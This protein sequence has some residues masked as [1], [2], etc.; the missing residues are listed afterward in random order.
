M[1]P[2]HERVTKLLTDTVTLLCKNGLSYDRELR[3]QGLLGITVDSKEVFLVSINDSFSCSSESSLASVTSPVAN[4]TASASSLPRNRSGDEVVDLTRLVETPNVFTAVQPPQLSS[5]IS[6]MQRGSQTRPRSAGSISQTKS[7][8]ATLNSLNMTLPHHHSH[9]VARQPPISTAV[10]SV[11]HRTSTS[12]RSSAERLAL[13]YNNQ[14]SSA[15]A[16]VESSAMCPRQRPHAGYIDNISNLMMACERQLAPRGSSHRQYHR[17]L[18]HAETSGWS[19]TD[20]HQ[21]MQH[22][23]VHQNMPAGD[24]PT[25][26]RRVTENI[27]IPPPPHGQP[28][29]PITLASAYVQRSDGNTLRY[30][31]SS[32]VIPGVNQQPMLSRQPVQ[33]IPRQ[34][35]A[36]RLRY[37]GEMQQAHATAEGRQLLN[38]AA[39]FQPPAKRHAPNHSPRQAMQSCY[40]AFMQ[41]Q[42]P[43][44]HGHFQHSHSTSFSQQMCATS[45]PLLPVTDMPT[46][47]TSCVTVTSS[48]A[49]KPPSSPVQSGRRSRSRHVEHIDL[50]GDDDTDG[51]FHIP[52]SSIVIQPDNTDF[53]N[54]PT[55]AET[56]DIVPVN[57]SDLYSDEFET[58]P[59]TSLPENDFPPL[60]RIHE[61]VPLDDG[62]DN[63]DGEVSVAETAGQA[64]SALFSVTDGLSDS[65]QSSASSRL[66]SAALSTL[67]LN[68]IVIDS[69]LARLTADESQQMTALCF[70][71]EDSD[72]HAQT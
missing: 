23:P 25:V 33:G 47:Q 38:T 27:S 60:S 5:S 61:I 49:V 9:L 36:Y 30:M 24:L 6:P 4:S 31:H 19:A 67:P 21:S 68:E 59:G 28:V 16:V 64:T 22:R 48:P 45:D 46:S 17:Q 14:H 10:T 57:T 8:A 69:Q 34:M 3:I 37:F 56:L 43:H 18:P 44:P 35:C 15:L 63:E 66:D 1:K 62:L 12:F 2:D 13:P 40:P 32:S 20:Q 52:V 53:L 51:A 55:E 70:V 42:L 72:M 26:G 65:G 11:H 50:C 41:G 58:A 71:T 54:A 7:Q 29:V 39:D